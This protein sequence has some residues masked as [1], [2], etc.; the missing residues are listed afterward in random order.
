MT[1]L[2]LND[3]WEAKEAILKDDANSTL[4]HEHGQLEEAKREIV[5]YKEKLD[6]YRAEAETYKNNVEYEASRY[7][8]AA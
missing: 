4:T 3:E 2:G 1:L 8:Q 6:Q 5:E 7:R